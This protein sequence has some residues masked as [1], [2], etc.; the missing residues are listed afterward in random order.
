MLDLS[1]VFAKFPMLETERFV[2]RAIT[3]GDAAAIFEIM[4][5]E[6]VTRYL[7]RHPMKTLNEAVQRV[8]GF[9]RTFANKEGIPWAVTER[10]SGQLIGTAVYWNLIPEHYRA[11]TGYVLSP[12][13]W[14]QGVMTEAISAVL[15]FG[16]TTMGLHSVEAQIDPENTAS[17]R[18]LERMGFVQ[19]G[20]FREDYYHIIKQEFTDT[21]VFSLLKD[22][23][24]KRVQ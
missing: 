24:V 12:A 14:G 3:D 20:Y 18:L 1:H 21:A 10:S 19:E 22:V 9:Q 17:Q 2:L 7:G 4:G 5:D 23:W 15:D 6:R 11:E 13:W 8:Q 16:F